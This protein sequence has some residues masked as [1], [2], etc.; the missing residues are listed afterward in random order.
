MRLSMHF[1]EIIRL[2]GERGL[3]AAMVKAAIKERSTTAEWARRRLRMALEADGIPL[4]L[5]S[6]ADTPHP[7]NFEAHG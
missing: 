3:S 4:P 5:L 7:S 2:R 6:D 1:P